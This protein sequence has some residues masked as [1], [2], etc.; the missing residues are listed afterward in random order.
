MKPM[1]TLLSNTKLAV[2]GGPALRSRP[3]AP[4]PSFSEAEIAAVNTVLR[5]GKVNY[6]T[7]NEGRLFESEFAAAVDC[8][9]AIAVTNGTAALEIA[10][11]SLGIGVGDE[12]I[13]PSRTFLA[14]A[15]C[16][17][18]R[19]AKPVFA[20]VDV[21]N[22]GLTAETIR[23]VLSPKTKAIIP[24]HLAGWPCEMTPIMELA[25]ERN[26]R[27]IE[28]CAQAQ[29]ATYAGRNVG[30]FGDMAAFSFC[31]DKIVTT[32]GEGGMVVTND[33]SLWE[34]A[35]SFKDH[36]KNYGLAHET[37]SSSDF[38][39]LHESFGTNLRLTEMQSAMGRVALANLE[40]SIDIRR[41]NAAILTQGFSRLPGLRLTRPPENVR[42]AY[43]KYYAFLRPEKLQKGW[44]RSRII[45]AIRAEGVPCFSGSCSE[46]YLEKA[47]PVSE[48][49]VPRLPVARELGE[50]SLVFMV[51]PTLSEEDMTDTYQ[52][53][54]K[55][56]TA[57]T[58]A[59]YSGLD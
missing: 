15:S 39:W 26:I 34:R 40:Q 11:Y 59:P 19:G 37:H 27:V 5:S 41:R 21:T 8:K 53:V 30:S 58:S 29:G 33:Q 57:A 42:H 45:A 48:R 54:E 13:V 9:Y 32:G 12:V 28:D 52:A 55:V 49:P 18:M 56:M 31:Q 10:L 16:V 25:R 1:P 35:W 51:H 14:T 4:W 36:G 7:G 24:V 47:F 50:T 3:F 20:D 17:V 44:D 22:Q 6:W 43:Y 2:E 46:V 23:K 38:R